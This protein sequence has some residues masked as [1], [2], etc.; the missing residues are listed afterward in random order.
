LRCIHFGARLQQNACFRGAGGNNENASE[1]LGGRPGAL[2]ENEVPELTAQ[3]YVTLE[4]YFAKVKSTG[5]ARCQDAWDRVER[6]LTQ[7]P[8]HWTNAYAVEQLLVHLFDEA[9]VES[10]LKVRAQEARGALRPGLVDYYNAEIMR[11]EL[12]PDNR[13]ALLGRLINDLQWRYTVNE[14]KRSYTKEI[15][16]KTGQ[17]F[18]GSLLVF[19]LS[20]L[21]TLLYPDLRQ[22]DV[23]LL[24]P[25]I[26][27]GC[28]GAAFSMLSSL[29]DRPAASDLDDLKLLRARWVLG[30]R[31]LI[32]AGAASVLYFFFVS[33]MVT[34]A[35]FPDF[36]AVTSVQT[37]AATSG[38]GSTASPAPASA[39]AA[40]LPS[41]ESGP[42]PSKVDAAIWLKFF[43]LLVVW[44]FVAGF[45]ERLIPGLL[46][47]TEARLDGSSSPDRFRP[48]S[49]ASE[50]ATPP[51]PQPAGPALATGASR[52]PSAAAGATT[53]P[54]VS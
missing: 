4:A 35:A 39:T 7:E 45:S 15:T 17:L 28:W 3:F 12:S 14:V 24:V 34:G 21:V 44:C 54:G 9:T 6:L 1:F 19:A 20:V 23:R 53:A 27:A 47:R 42:A 16:L 30:S 52:A 22:Y 32:G 33:G 48:T 46:A 26:L 10:E 43:S 50:P 11:P 37:P 36:K 31:L 25:A 2:S 38:P 18:I 51:G 40:A 41:T 49:S 5:A 13:R 8:R 29:R